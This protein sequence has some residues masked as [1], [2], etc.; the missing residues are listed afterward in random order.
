MPKKHCL[1][2]LKNDFETM[3]HFMLKTINQMIKILSKMIPA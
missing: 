2:L 1:K 3:V